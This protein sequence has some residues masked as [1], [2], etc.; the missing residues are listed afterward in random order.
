MVCVRLGSKWVDRSGSRAVVQI[1]RRSFRKSGGR[2]GE[3]LCN[4]AVSQSGG[5]Q[6]VERVGGQAC[7][8][9]GGLRTDTETEGRRDNAVLRRT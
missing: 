6:S 8:L 9:M 1:V 4:K 2:L 5:Y 7:G 3:R